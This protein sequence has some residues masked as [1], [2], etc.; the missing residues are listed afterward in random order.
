MAMLCRAVDG[1]KGLVPRAKKILQMAIYQI[2][3]WCVLF[4]FLYSIFYFLSTIF[5]IVY[6]FFIVLYNS[7]SFILHSLFFANLIIHIPHYQS[8]LSHLIYIFFSITYIYFSIQL[9]ELKL[10]FDRFAV[11]ACITPPETVQA[12]TEAGIVAPRRYTTALL[13]LMLLMLLMSLI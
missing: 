2:Y 3:K 9:A 12:L 7:S 13:L 6:F 5:C 8:T 11:D 4:Y 1:I 10:V